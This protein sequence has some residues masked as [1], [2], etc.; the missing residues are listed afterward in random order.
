[1]SKIRLLLF[2]FFVAYGTIMV[3]LFYLQVLH[4]I[5]S[6]DYLQTRKIPPERGNIFDRNGQPLVTNQIKYQLYI[7]PKYVSDEEILKIK[8][9]RELG[10]EEA[11]I[12]AKFDKTKDWIAI[13]SGI[14]REKHDAIQALQLPGTGF[15][16]EASRNYPEGSQSAH[17]LGF[18]GKN[19]DGES[20]GYVGI[21]GYYDKDLAGFPGLIRSDKDL[22][23]RPIFLGTQ[24]KIDP[25]NGRDLIL[26]IDKS[27]QEIIK[28]KLIAGVEKY[29]AKEGCVVVVQPATLEILG[30]SCVPDFDP[31]TYYKY[32]E[33]FYKNG[34]ISSLY[35]P[36][37]TFKP[38]VMAAAINEG[39]LKPDSLYDETGQVAVGEYKIK[40]WNDQYEGKITMTR[41]LEKSSN[42]GMVYAGEKL[43]NKKLLEY[44]KNY[45]FGNLTGIDLQGEVPGYLRPTNDWHSID[46][47][48][49]TFGQGLVVSPIQMVRAFASIINGGNLLTPHIV[50]KLISPQ[51]EQTVEPRVTR[52]MIKKEVSDQ[53]KKM[54]VSTIENG[55]TKFLKPK[56]YAV[57]GKTGTAQIALKGHYDA[58]KT[59]ASF[60]GFS[61]I[62]NP[63]FMALVV[64]N[65]PSTSQWGSETAAP[66]FF[67]IAK[68]LIVYYNIVPE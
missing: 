26:T 25:E 11:S 7:E 41:V 20:V 49:A 2:F 29:K 5:T 15:N 4:P 36:G 47:A 3:R 64:V 16:E 48:T 44:I 6:T 61:P 9:A 8:L 28:R 35:E 62:Q 40:T 51:R 42:V 56:G 52:T 19:Q 21:E 34:A 12:S 39:V 66:I 46:Y 24:E 32:D 17:L 31:E 18:V 67:D 63:K 23:G 60:I 57:G 13:A 37:S 58:S 38:L 68:E 55:E 59:I 1:M 30:L 14:T 53:I 22:I 54:L 50:Q 27:V 43:G 33:S 65:E 10:V 45:G